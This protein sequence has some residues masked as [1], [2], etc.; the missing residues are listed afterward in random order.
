MPDLFLSTEQQLSSALQ[1]LNKLSAG[2]PLIKQ[3]TDVIIRHLAG[4][5]LSLTL[6]QPRSGQAQTVKLAAT[7]LQGKLVSGGH[8]QS[9]IL[10]EAQNTLLQFLAKQP[11][12]AELV[13]TLSPALAQTLFKLSAGKVQVAPL[14]DKP[15]IIS[16]KVISA[17]GSQLSLKIDGQDKLPPL[18]LPLNNA[19]QSFTPGQVLLVQL[20]PLANSYQVKILSPTTTDLGQIRTSMPSGS[21]VQTSKQGHVA[22]SPPITISE[23]QA[24]QLTQGASTQSPPLSTATGGPAV[25]QS[26]LQQSA[27]IESPAL[28]SQGNQVSVKSLLQA[29]QTQGGNEPRNLPLLST[30]SELKTDK[31]EVVLKSDGRIQLLSTPS[32]V[33]AQ[34]AINSSLLK[35]LQLLRLPVIQQIAAANP[36]TVPISGQQA[37]IQP[38]LNSNAELTAGKHATAQPAATV[39]LSSQAST[40]AERPVQ[41]TKPNITPISPELKLQIEQLL[42]QRLAIADSPSQ[43]LGR[44]EE[45]LSDPLLSRETALKPLI[46]QLL[47]QTKQALPQ[48]TN[49]DA[50]QIKQLLMSPALN[51]SPVQLVSPAASQG[52]LGGLV[53]MLQVSL[54]SRLLRDQPSQLERIAQ[55]LEPMLAG[56][57]AVPSQ[58]QSGRALLDFFQ[59][60]Q[61]HQLLKEIGRLLASHQGSKLASAEQV[62]QGQENIYYSL[63]IGSGDSRKDI[64]L[65]IRRDGGGNK[66]SL[67]GSENNKQWHLTM[68][69]SVGDSGELLTK[70]KLQDTDLK[71]DFY[72]S[73]EATRDKV[74]NF[75]PLLKKRL[76]SLGIEVSHSKC[77]LGKI[78]ATLQQRPYQIFETQA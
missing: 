71:V 35:D 53:A 7:Q 37:S 13:A 9:R 42:R 47:S 5:Q 40:S 60:E 57:K 14:S 25:N 67:Q 21:E 49:Q 33:V 4:N 29:I 50:A 23:S 62:M 69:L 6:A 15:I 59:V 58:A 56:G 75:L 61:K 16:A 3:A 41:A 44:I 8:Y 38:S 11:A 22:L 10:V 52:L 70:A 63:P 78:P 46:E 19:R 54:A 51:L 66:K 17:N 74:L 77:Q 32:T 2:S 45:A 43:A 31:L 28:A 39:E 65:L 30:L 27:L 20:I 73:N 76:S 1:Q 26:L 12:T 72:A 68:K 64:E 24:R 55:A 36:A 48:G 34:L 18:N